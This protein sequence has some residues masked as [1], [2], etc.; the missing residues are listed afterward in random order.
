MPAPLVVAGLWA[1]GRWALTRA[2][3][4]I[5]EGAVVAGRACLSKAGQMMSRSAV[6]TAAREGV[7]E[8]AEAGAKAAATQGL[9]AMQRLAVNSAATGLILTGA[10]TAYVA[11]DVA[12][13]NALTREYVM[14]GVISTAETLGDLPLAG[15]WLESAVINTADFA[16]GMLSHGADTAA[17]GAA[18]VAERA[19]FEDQAVAGRVAYFVT[20]KSLSL[21]VKLNQAPEEER[22]AVFIREAE[23]SGISQADMV[24]YLSAYPDQIEMLRARGVNLST[25]LPGLDAAIAARAETAASTPS[26]PAVGAS[27]LTGS[28]MTAA[29]VSA[30][31]AL[32]TRIANTKL[33]YIGPGLTAAYNR[34]CAL[35]DDPESGIKLSEAFDWARMVANWDIPIISTIAR[36]LAVGIAAPDVK[37]RMSAFARDAVD[38]NLVGMDG[39]V[40][41]LKGHGIRKAEPAE[42]NAHSVPVYGD[43]APA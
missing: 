4:Y 11:A 14:P 9:T 43:L 35:K 2:A 7:E 29:E 37:E 27:A 25:A 39:G 36:S 31:L 42:D 12:S 18:Q 30:E 5:I 32:D 6:Q 41:G 19:G 20:T 16:L 28:F 26:A 33:F 24:R 22:G 8:V 3:P 38:G 15:P 13:G 34:V 23:S 1:A 40:L 17:E 21:A 10:K